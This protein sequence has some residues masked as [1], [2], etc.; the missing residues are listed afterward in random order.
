MK[1]IRSFFARLSSKF[2]SENRSAAVERFKDRGVNWVRAAPTGS[3]EPK[4]PAE[5]SPERFND[6]GTNWVT[7]APAGSDKPRKPVNAKP[8]RFNDKNRFE[9]SRH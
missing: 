3:A 2:S 4:P 7:D 5:A 9:D 1:K 6:R 8:S